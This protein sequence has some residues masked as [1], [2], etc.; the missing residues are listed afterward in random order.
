MT[1]EE[2]EAEFRAV[3]RDLTFVIKLQPQR[4]VDVNKALRRGL[5]FLLRQCGLRCLSIEE[6]SHD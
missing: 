6:V 3:R 5:K 4:G 2:E 1:E